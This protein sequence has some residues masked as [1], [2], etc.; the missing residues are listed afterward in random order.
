MR[1]WRIPEDQYENWG[2]DADNNIIDE[3][4]LQDLLDD[5]MPIEH[6]AQLEEI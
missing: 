1:Q 6:L 4:L 3:A 5:G 2:A